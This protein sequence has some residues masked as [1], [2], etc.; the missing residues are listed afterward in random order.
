MS[1][2]DRIP[3]T[4]NPY[5]SNFLRLPGPPKNPGWKTKFGHYFGAAFYGICTAYLIVMLFV[6]IPLL[7]IIIGAAAITAIILFLKYVVIPFINK[8]A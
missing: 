8:F 1:G 5:N 3:N 4:P 6:S 2:M 7:Y